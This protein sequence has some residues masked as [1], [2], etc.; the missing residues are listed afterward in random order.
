MIDSVQVT[1]EPVQSI[2]PIGKLVRLGLAGLF[3][4]PLFSILGPGG[5]SRFRNPHILSEPSAWLIHILMLITFVILVGALA[6]RLAGE[7]F[8]RPWQVGAMV[9]AASVVVAAGGIGVIVGGSVWGFPLADVVWWFDVMMLTEQVAATLLAIAL[10]TSGC[11]IGVWPA[12][13]AR[14]RGEAPSTENGLACIVG[15]HLLDGWEARRRRTA[16]QG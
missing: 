10:G 11:E 2:G 14:W 15:L 3:A 6:A 16:A 7:R 12:L 9:M 8:R 1:H 13:I 5:S 4:Y